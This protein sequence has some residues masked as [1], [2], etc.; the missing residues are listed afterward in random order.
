MING[1]IKFFNRPFVDADNV[2][3]TTN[4]STAGFM[5]VPNTVSAWTGSTDD[6]ITLTF[7]EQAVDRI[8]ITNHNLENYTIQ[9]DDGGLQDFTNVITIDS[10]TPVTGISETGYARNTSYYEF[11]TITT[12]T[13]VLTFTGN[14]APGTIEFLGITEE[15]GTFE[16]PAVVSK[17]VFNRRIKKRIGFDNNTLPTF[18]TESLSATIKFKENFEQNDTELIDSLQSLLT[19]C[20]VWFSGGNDQGFLLERRPFRLQDIY[21]VF[22]TG[23]L[24]NKWVQGFYGRG[25]S[26]QLKLDEASI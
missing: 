18:N 26:A 7:L 20:L 1:N 3:A 24:S 6:T 22:I 23:N 5:V 4:Q 2:V 21:L 13:I 15:L 8:I 10:S 25:I 16:C 12:T 9:Y 19:S 14:S 11:D 17:E